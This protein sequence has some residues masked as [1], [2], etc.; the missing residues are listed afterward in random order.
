M[1]MKLTQIVH[2]HD[3]KP[4]VKFWPCMTSSGP[5]PDFK[6]IEFF[7]FCRPD[8]IFSKW[9]QKPV[10]YL[11]LLIFSTFTKF[12]STFMPNNGF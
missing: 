1:I 8:L 11:I 3:I 9:V 12:P 6:Y 10:W 7:V 2:I 5:G 4:C